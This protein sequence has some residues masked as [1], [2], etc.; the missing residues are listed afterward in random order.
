MPRSWSPDEDFAI[1]VEALAAYD[2]TKALP[3]LVVIVTG[4]G[5]L[6]EAFL[7][8]VA[9]RRFK[10]VLA[11]SPSVRKSTTEMCAH[12]VFSSGSTSA[13]S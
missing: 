6:R 5:P 12:E 13:T 10:K 2:A 11:T 7:A 3:R 4:K 1:L 9:A 8:D